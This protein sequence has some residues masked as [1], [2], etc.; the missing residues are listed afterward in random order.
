M[1][2]FDQPDTAGTTFRPFGRGARGEKV[3][4][5]RARL[6]G[7]G[8]LTE[9]EPSGGAAG[10]AVY[11]GDVELGVRQFQQAR[12]L[13]VDG[14]IGRETFRALE[15]ARWRLGDRVLL[16]SPGWPMAGDD[17]VA[18]Q[19]RLLE[20]G[21]DCGKPDGV[22]GGQ[23]SAALRDFQRNTGL[24]AD[25]TCGPSTFKALS[26]LVRTV[27]GGR[28]H[29]MRESARL[30]RNGHQHTG[31]L[32]VIDP[33]HGPTDPGGT[34]DG[35]TEAD[36]V[37][38][39][40]TRLEGRLTALGVQAF[41]TRG[42]DRDADDRARAAFANEADADLVVSL[43]VDAHTNP[44]AS[45]AA[46]FFYG[47]PATGQHSAYGEQFASLVQKELV[48]R[49]DLHDCGVYPKTWDLL[50][51]TRMPAVRA[52][53]GYLTNPGDRERLRQFQFRDTVA[54]AVCAAVQRLFLPPD[55]DA[56]TGTLD[57][58]AIMAGG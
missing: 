9:A 15:E 47:N 52:E 11:D 12:G 32:I 21:F 42:H 17:V 27:V 48:A 34:W 38:D 20:L 39:I 22:F 25:G 29:A 56:P 26:R 46:A 1:P 23:T 3:S 40:A 37:F 44:A 8:L 28:A 16:Y 14:V 6:V 45:G 19:R 55:D 5:V 57:I 53:V 36:L 54:E 50:R 51:I 7:Q 30:Y 31:R 43:H 33:G 24:S 4:V 41:L 2:S 10:E 18:L 35:V 49:T 13:I 58:P